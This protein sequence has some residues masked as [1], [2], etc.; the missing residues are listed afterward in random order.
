VRRGKSLQDLVTV[1]GNRF[2]VSVK[3]LITL[4]G[5]GLG[6]PSLPSSRPATPVLKSIMLVV[7]DI[8]RSRE[9]YTQVLGF[10]AKIDAG[11]FSTVL[12]P[13]ENK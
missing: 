5:T 13:N 1:N 6:I 3:I 8:N 12:T 4:K 11:D 2:L 10:E 9:F 7:K